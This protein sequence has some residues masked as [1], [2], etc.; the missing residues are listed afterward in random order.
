MLVFRSFAIGLLA[1]CVAL[2][3]MRP[4]VIVVQPPAIELAQVALPASMEPRPASAPPTI[5]DVAPGVSDDQL[6]LAIR[7][8]PGERIAFA[9]DVAVPPNLPASY[10]FASRGPRSGQFYDLVVSGLAGDRRVLVLMH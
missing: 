2:L 1:A 10:V 6:A 7:L 8:A 5:V 4:S 3:A 9:N